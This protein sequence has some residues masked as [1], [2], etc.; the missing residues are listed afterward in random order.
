MKDPDIRK[1]LYPH[2]L[3]QDTPGLIVPEVWMRYCVADVIQFNGTITG[4]EIKSDADTL[5]RLPKQS[6]EY[7]QHCQECWIVTT[8]KFAQ[9]AEQ[10]LPEWWGILCITKGKGAEVIRDSKPNPNFSLLAVCYWLSNPQL[11]KLLKANGVKGYSKL[12]KYQL[13]ARAAELPQ[14]N[15][16]SQIISLLR[17]EKHWWLDRAVAS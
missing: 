9:K 6:E 17:E 12:M 3:R 11:K 8:E 13:A 14:E 7:D 10:I 5:K 2:L 15:L 1:I 4:Y 16:L